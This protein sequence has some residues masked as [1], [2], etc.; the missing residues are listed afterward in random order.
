VLEEDL[1]ALLK[2]KLRVEVVTRYEFDGEKT[3]AVRLFWDGEVFSESG[4][5]L[6]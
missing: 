1:V 2:D 6:E 4:E 5:I 3:M